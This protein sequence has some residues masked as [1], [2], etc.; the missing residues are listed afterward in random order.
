MQR[1]VN[2]P[3]VLKFAVHQRFLLT[4]EKDWRGIREKQGGS[5]RTNSSAGNLIFQGCLLTLYY[6]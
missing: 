5:G 6:M 4:V 1:V 3:F 2:R